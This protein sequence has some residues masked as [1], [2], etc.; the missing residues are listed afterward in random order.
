MADY[1]LLMHG[2]GAPDEGAAWDPYLAKLRA[3]GVF[4][5]GSSIGGG[6]CARKAGAPG[7]LAGHLTGFVRITAVDLDDARRW[8]AGNPVFEAGGTIEIRELPRD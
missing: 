5:G 8:L 7:A 1:L 4:Q 2:D 6:A 3:A